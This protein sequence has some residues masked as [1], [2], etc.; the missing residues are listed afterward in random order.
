MSHPNPLGERLARLE[1]QLD[2]L[3]LT[4]ARTHADLREHLDWQRRSTD[5]QNERLRALENSSEQTRTHL[6]WMK[7]GWLSAQAL[8]IAW[9]G[10]KRP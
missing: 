4:S 3:V 6:R 7:A 8:V 9:L 10:A 5:V 1:T 2:Q